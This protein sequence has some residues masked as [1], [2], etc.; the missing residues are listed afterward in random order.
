MVNLN[1]AL[2]LPVRVVCRNCGRDMATQ[3]PGRD[4]K[5]AVLKCRECGYEVTLILEPQTAP[6]VA[7]TGLG[8]PGYRPQPK[9]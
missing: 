1:L 8:M 3:P 7:A 2:S 4:P 5:G 6:G 9:T